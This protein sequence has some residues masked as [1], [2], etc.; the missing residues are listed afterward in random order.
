MRGRKLAAVV[1]ALAIAAVAVVVAGPAGARSKASCG[2]VAINEQA[3]AGST[4]NTYVAKAV[5]EQMGCKVK[6]TQIAEIPVYQ[7]LA[8][9]KSDAVLEDWQ[10]VA[11]YKQYITK[12]KTVVMGGP[13]GVVGHIGWY[14]PTYL[15]KQHPE[16]KT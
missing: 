13:N 5:L 8:D 14:I 2:T 10:H 11:Q 4:A 7:A 6:I 15:M 9:G 12:Q 16:F 3:W 1:G